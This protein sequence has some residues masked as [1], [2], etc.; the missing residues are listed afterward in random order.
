MAGANSAG[1]KH[2]SRLMDTGHDSCPI[3]K[4]GVAANRRSSRSS[5]EVRILARPDRLAP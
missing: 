5:P 2:T 1:T 4:A 3:G